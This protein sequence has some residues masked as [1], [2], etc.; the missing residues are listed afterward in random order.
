M[1]TALIYACREV[2]EMI[3]IL[4]ENGAD[5]KIKCSE[6]KTPFM[7]LMNNWV[8]DPWKRFDRFPPIKREI[9]PNILLE[10]VDLLLRHG[11]DPTEKFLN[12]QT[13][14][15][16]EIFARKKNHASLVFS[17]MY[18]FITH[19]FLVQEKEMFALS[20]YQKEALLHRSTE[21]QK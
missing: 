18:I 13:L 17:M 5:P 3:K 8:I 14:F 16:F 9:S 2:P 15:E 20:S 10:S 6:G 1:E 11:A 12:N 19:G 4:L 21:I 7:Y